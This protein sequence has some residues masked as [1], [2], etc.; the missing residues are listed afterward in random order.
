M[1]REAEVVAQ[2][3]AGRRLFDEGRFDEAR[4]I[5]LRAASD[6]AALGA[7]LNVGQCDLRAGRPHDAEACARRLIETSNGFAPAWALLGEALAATEHYAEAADAFR[8]ALSIAPTHGL[9]WG[10]LGDVQQR[11]KAFEAARES[12]MRA[13]RETPD[14][15]GT[16]AS[17]VALKRM[18]C[19]W[20]RLDRLSAALRQTVREGRGA[21]QPL[22]FLGEGDDPAEQRLC[23]TAWVEQRVRTSDTPARIETTK[24]SPRIGF[25]SYGFG[26]HPTAILGSEMIEAMRAQGV[27]LHLICTG[28]DDAS[29]YRRRLEVAAPIHDVEHLSPQA[30]A[31]RIR[32]LGIDVLV[33]LDGYSRERVPSVF[34]ER[35]CALQ[36][37]WLGFPG[38]TGA[39]CFDY[40]IADAFVLPAELEPQFTERVAR[41]PRCYQPNDATRR[42]HA[43]PPR[44]ALGLPADGVVYVCFNTSFKL[45]PRSFARMMKVLREVPDSVLWLL[46]G[47][48]RAA[49]RLRVTASALGVAPERL[50]FLDKQAHG[51]YLAAYAH[52]DLFLDTEH[53]N[54]HTT[55]SDA[56]WAGCPVLSRPG[57]TFASRV[58]GSLNHHAGLDE[59]NV[60]DDRAFVDLA[61]R[62]GRDPAYRADLRARLA[63]AR[64]ESPLFDA[65]GFA[66]DF[67][68][69]V[70]SLLAQEHVATN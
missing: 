7:A 51:A 53:Y 1:E 2:N 64:T 70:R 24:D 35:P 55:A 8:H 3:E 28:P 6:P 39:R 41:L 25:V 61:V 57:Q 49:E 59:L 21:V 47:P 16:L 62:V 12:Y 43:P 46:N 52:A 48:G 32:E 14:D 13:L 26:A 45:N 42:L 15:V 36:L 9:L 5:F 60:T 23:A 33:D 58:A 69:L 56:M 27:D 30:C 18:L 10:R 38:T 29:G 44:E 54:A 4:D 68:V 66:A 11:D 63:A 34:A 22:S 40:V 50:V 67:M 65:S 37:V 20:D 19:D 31:Q 17:L